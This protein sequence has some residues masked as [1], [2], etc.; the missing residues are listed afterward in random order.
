MQSLPSELM[1]LFTFLVSLFSSLLWW[2][3]LFGCGYGGRK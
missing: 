2:L 3:V 1:P